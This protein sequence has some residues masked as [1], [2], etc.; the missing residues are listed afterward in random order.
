M[1]LIL[2]VA[3]KIITLS[4]VM[5]SVIVLNVA[6]PVMQIIIATLVKRLNYRVI[7]KDTNGLVKWHGRGW[8]IRITMKLVGR[9]L[10]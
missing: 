10:C 9:W 7:P 5:L 4:V 8:Q 1:F 2:S 3:I 6:A